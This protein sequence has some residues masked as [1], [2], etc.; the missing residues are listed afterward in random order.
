[1]LK[2]QK[3]LIMF[4]QIHLLLIASIPLISTCVFAQKV[5]YSVISVPQEEKYELTQI[6]TDRDEVC[7]P[8]VKR[9]QSKLNWFTNRIIGVSQNGKYLAFISAKDGKT[10]IYVKDMDGNGRPIQRTNRYSVIDFSYSPDGQEICF[11]EKG[12]NTNNIFTTNSTQGFVCRQIATGYQDYSPIYSN[13]M[14]QIY[15]VRKENNK[16][17]IWSY[18]LAKNFMSSYAIGIDPCSAGKGTLLVVRKGLNNNCEIWRIDTKLGLEEC[19]VSD[20][21]HSFSTPSLSPNGKWI[22]L[23][24][25]SKLAVNDKGNYY[26]NTDIYVCRPDGSQLIQLTYHAADDL[27]PAWSEDGKYIYFVS[28]RGN[29]LGK[30]NV[31]R[32]KFIY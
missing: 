29:Y 24:G 32:M 28:Q 12:R 18:D 8:I 19:I 7:M 30:A 31:W 13:D 4:K 20:A 27:S 26:H 11:T 9:T 6:T 15:F 21:N 23:T 10:N 14:E 25:S 17:G 16:E 22:L 5:D 1:M 2:R 3:G